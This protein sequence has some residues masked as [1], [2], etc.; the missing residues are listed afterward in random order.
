VIPAEAVEAAH[1]AWRE[2]DAKEGSIF[3][4][5]LRA[6]LEAAAPIILSHEADR[7]R[8]ERIESP[9]GGR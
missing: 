6:A 7:S 9:W 2:Q 3:E 4:Y 8:L 1:R 5:N